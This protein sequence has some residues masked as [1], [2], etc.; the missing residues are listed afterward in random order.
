MSPRK[1][2]TS[3][4]HRVTSPALMLDAL[5]M[6]ECLDYSW[7]CPH[8]LTLSEMDSYVLVAIKEGNE[9]L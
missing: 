1:A 9:R 8:M 4:T 5:A 3:T 7:A 2:H 6:V